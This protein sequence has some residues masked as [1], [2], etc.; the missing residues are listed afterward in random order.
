[1]NTTLMVLLFRDVKSIDSCRLIQCYGTL[2]RIIEKSLQMQDN[3][4]KPN[5]FNGVYER[6]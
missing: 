1:M 3:T 4:L 5:S 6:A 2:Q